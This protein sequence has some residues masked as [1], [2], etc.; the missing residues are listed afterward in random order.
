MIGAWYRVRIT[1]GPGHQGVHVEWTWSPEEPSEDEM[2]EWF[3][4]IATREYMDWPIGKVEK[5]DL[6]EDVRLE[7]IKHYQ[8]RIK[9]AVHMLKVLG[10]TT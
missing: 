1:Y 5:M 10:E 7:K 6:P 2:K 8:A 3:D 4:E 9:G